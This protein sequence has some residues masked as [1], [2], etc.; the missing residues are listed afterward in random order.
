MLKVR[1]LSVVRGDRILFKK[2]SFELN[3]GKVLKIAGANGSGKTTLL[4]TVC[5]L[6][7][8]AAGS[9]HWGQKTIQKAREEYFESMACLTHQN[10]LQGEL[11]VQENLQV[12][13]RDQPLNEL[14]LLAQMGLEK[15]ARVP[16]RYLSQG[17]QRRLALAI[18]ISKKAKLWIL[19]E[20]LVSLDQIGINLVKSLCERH[21]GSGGMILLAT[22]QEMEFAG[23]ISELIRLGA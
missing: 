6:I 4:R 16:A 21:V 3:S 14:T 7:Q 20:P 15:A 13:R 2:L 12:N 19:D 23:G 10:S 22:H 8:P 18:L 5:G 1:N 11:T 17:Q 9:I